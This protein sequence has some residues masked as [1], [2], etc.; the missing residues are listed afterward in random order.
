MI[1]VFQEATKED[2]YEDLHVQ[3]K[4][5]KDDISLQLTS[6][7]ENLTTM[8][9]FAAKL[10][11][12][13][14]DYNIMFESF[15]PIG[16]IANIGVLN[17]DNTFVTK[18]GAIDL[19]GRISFNDEKAR[20]KYISG[21]VQDLTKD[22]N[23]IIRAA[24]PI[25]ADGEVVG[26]LYGVV[27]ISTINERYKKMAQELDA[28]LFVYEKTSGD[29]VIDTVHDELGNISFLKDR[30]YNEEYSYEEFAANDKGFTSFASAY[31]NE[32]VHMHYSTIDELGWMIALVRYDSQVFAK[33]NFFTNNL[34]AVFF[35][36]LSIMVLYML[37]LMKNER[38]INLVTTCASDVRR[39]LLETSGNQNNIEEA[40][41]YVCNF[42]KGRSVVFF[43][44]NEEHNYFMPDYEDAIL[45]DNDK[46]HFQSELIRYA[47][48][49]YIQ[50]NAALNIMCIK[51]DKHL[52]HTNPKFYELLKN[53]KIS[54]IAFSAVV[55]SDEQITILA[56]TNAKRGKAARM[57][58][59][60]ISACFYMALHNQ[61]HL[62]KT[63]IAATTDPLTG[64]FNRVSYKVDVPVFDE[65]KHS[66]FS[67]IFIDVN[68][69]HLINNMYGHA[70]GDEMLVYVANALKKVF[71]GNKIYRMGG[72]EFL[73]F[74]KDTRQDVIEESIKYFEEQL[75]PKNY[76]VAIG[77][78]YRSMNNNTEE[79]VK[80]AEVKMYEAKAKY[81]QNKEQENVKK[82]ETEDYVNINTGIREID[83]MLSVMREHYSGI[84]R[85]SLD[86][87]VASRILMPA[88]LKYNEKEEHFS[89]LF[90]KYVNKSVDSDHRRSMM[91]FLNYDAIKLQLEEG[92]T[93]KIKYT[94]NQGESMVLSVYKLNDSKNGDDTLWVFARD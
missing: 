70:A 42:V 24:V 68:E 37:I 4:Q 79:M 88:Y 40:L 36:I 9:N 80:E 53:G 58:A 75:K 25:T 6:D 16:L 82:H 13:G 71:Y 62:N 3:T 72:D 14:E 91:A 93:P 60:K 76:H 48:E 86:S 74:V 23:E 77:V 35:A 94:K 73:V 7:F 61:T 27:K 31:R 50:N 56:V 18:A 65:E 8:A 83:T 84:Y 44:V 87:D 89:Q 90:V 15:K 45:T 30:K 19:N 33:M 39:I 43:N 17:P 92:N 12:D 81:Y 2:A 22:D 41:K 32:N 85:V 5:I 26:I 11:K 1:N 47:N 46:V 78:S 34:F 21:R 69:L 29:L 51:P 38:Q 66:D 28:Q 52:L 59:E 63:E 10:Y 67:C 64:V 49:Y 54:E 55:G 20:G 57:L